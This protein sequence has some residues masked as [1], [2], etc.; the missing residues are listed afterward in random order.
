MEECEKI[1]P[2]DERIWFT[3]YCKHCDG[4]EPDE[5]TEWYFRDHQFQMLQIQMLHKRC[6]DWPHL[7]VSGGLMDDATQI[8]LYEYWCGFECEL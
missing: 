2:D 6:C 3:A 7:G 5:N 1:S 8:K 4:D